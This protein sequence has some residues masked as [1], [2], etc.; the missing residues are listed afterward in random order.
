MAWIILIVAGLFEVA[1]SMGLPYTEGFT[2]LWPSVLTL[3]AIVV[4][5]YLLAVA[6]R[7]IPVG[8]GYAVW[9]GIGVLGGA[10]FGIIFRSEP[11]SWLR[12]LCLCALLASVA[13]L[14]ATTPH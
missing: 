9:V 7:T 3:L 11:I 2:R 10:L 12:A 14:K 1:W 8:T 6:V 5:M 4:S 13:G